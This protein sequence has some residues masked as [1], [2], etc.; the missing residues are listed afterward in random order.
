MSFVKGSPPEKADHDSREKTVIA[1]RA[2][3]CPWKGGLNTRK[4]FVS[5]RGIGVLVVWWR[6]R[7]RRWWRRRPLLVLWVVWRWFRRIRLTWFVPFRR[8]VLVGFSRLARLSRNRRF[9]RLVVPR[10]RGMRVARLGCVLVKS[11]IVLRVVTFVW[12]RLWVRFVP[13]LIIVLE[14]SRGRRVVFR[15]P[16]LSSRKIV[17]LLVL[18]WIMVCRLRLWRIR[19]VR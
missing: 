16:I 14:M 10:S 4:S 2:M 17:P 18:R 3:S 8:L 1:W 15:I 9:F 13:L 11:R 5:A 19:L 6:R 12:C 7:R